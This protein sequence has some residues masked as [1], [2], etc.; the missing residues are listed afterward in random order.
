M[1]IEVLNAHGTPV[2]A[3]VRAASVLGEIADLDRVL[4]VCMG[5][6][7]RALLLYAENLTP[8][9]FDLRSGEAGE[10]LQKLRTYGLK[11]ALIACAEDLPAGHFREMVGEEARG[12][13]F[14]IFPDRDAGL[15]WLVL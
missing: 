13:D 5:N 8:R 6:G 1:K 4:E 12:S 7:A 14:R 9:F 3:G 10:V 15:A 2:V 11:L